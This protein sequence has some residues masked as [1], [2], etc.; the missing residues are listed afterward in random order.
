MRHL[1]TSH[2]PTEGLMLSLQELA[3]DLVADDTN[4][5]ENLTE[6]LDLAVGETDKML[7][8]V[9]SQTE[10]AQKKLDL[11][12]D[13]VERCNNNTE[14]SSN[15]DNLDTLRS[16]HAKCRQEQL[17]MLSTTPDACTNRDVVKDGLHYPGCVYTGDELKRANVTDSC[18]ETLGGWLNNSMPLLEDAEDACAAESDD[19]TLANKTASCK[20]DQ[21]DFELYYCQWVGKVQSSWG[22]YETCYSTSSDLYYSSSALEEKQEAGRRK[23]YNMATFV[24]CLLV[25]IKNNWKNHTNCPTEV[26]TAELDIKYLDAPEKLQKDNIMTSATKHW[27]CKETWNN[28]ADGYGENVPWAHLLDPCEDCVMLS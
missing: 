19:L 18:M 11:L 20:E 27:P 23:Q 6:I 26:N 22:A 5:S 7:Q 21:T 14:S 4:C 10:T 3:T 25:V 24:K 15:P 2:K 28:S 9:V 13:N 8:G 16:N 17:D 12:H 1:A